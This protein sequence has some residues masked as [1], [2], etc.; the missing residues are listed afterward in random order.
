[1]NYVLCTAY[2]IQL[3]GSEEEEKARAIARGVI[4][5]PARAPAAARWISLRQEAPPLSLPRVPLRERRTGA[6][7]GECSAG[8]DFLAVAPT[9]RA[10][11]VMGFFKRLFG[12]LG[13]SKTKCNILIVGLDDAGKTTIMNQIMPSKVFTM[14]DLV[15]QRNLRAM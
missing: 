6:A 2:S 4:A 11:I 9:R 3:S 15:V 13:L 10:L 8:R 5:Q 7:S 12:A 14:L 1:M